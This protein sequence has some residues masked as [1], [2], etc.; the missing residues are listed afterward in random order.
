MTYSRLISGLMRVNAQRVLLFT[1][2]LFALVLVY[3]L[4]RLG[5]DPT[6]GDPVPPPDPEL[7][8]LPPAPWRQ[9]Q[10]VN[11]GGNPFVSARLTEW[12]EQVTPQPTPPVEDEPA[13]DPDPPLQLPPEPSHIQLHYHGMLTQLDGSVRAFV[14]APVHGWQR[15]VKVNQTI[16]DFTVVTIDASHIEI[17]GATE[18]HRLPRGETVTLEIP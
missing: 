7:E 4:H 10:T 12:M 1:A 18:A 15:A 5:F 2:L 16:K 14:S 11:T 8:S 3:A 6:P 13:P 17:Q 9:V